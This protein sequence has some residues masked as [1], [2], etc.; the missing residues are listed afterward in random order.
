MELKLLQDINGYCIDVLGKL[1]PHKYDFVHKAAYNH[2]YMNKTFG[3]N[4]PN[5]I[6]CYNNKPVP[7]I[8]DGNIEMTYLKALIDLPPQKYGINTW[9]YKT[10]VYKYIIDHNLTAGVS[11]VLHTGE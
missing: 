2:C 9:L 8:E 3:H 6:L 5:P 11:E 4:E 10:G 1:Y 7:L